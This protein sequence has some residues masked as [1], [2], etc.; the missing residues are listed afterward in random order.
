MEL[1]LALGTVGGTLRVHSGAR[2]AMKITGVGSAQELAM[3]AVCAG[4]ASNLAALRALATEGIQHG[5]MAL[6]ARSVAVAAG[7]RG[8]EVERVAA[9]IHRA[10]RITVVAATEVLRVLRDGP[11]TV[12]SGGPMASRNPAPVSDVSHTER[13][14]NGRRSYVQSCSG[15]FESYPLTVPAEGPRLGAAEAPDDEAEDHARRRQRPRARRGR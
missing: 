7:A 5:H 2:L 4:M 13:V 15:T 10:G 9:T 11:E 14:G 6:H 3:L 8:A 12:T 1:P